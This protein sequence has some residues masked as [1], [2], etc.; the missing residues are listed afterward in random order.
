M[1]RLFDDRFYHER[2][3]GLKR[4]K[5]TRMLEKPLHPFIMNCVAIR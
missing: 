5:G 1:I 2:S 4:F 3:G